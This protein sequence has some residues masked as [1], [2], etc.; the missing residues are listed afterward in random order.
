MAKLNNEGNGP[1][2]EGCIIQCHEGHSRRWTYRDFE[3]T[4]LCGCS[5]G[6]V[7]LKDCPARNELVDPTH[8]MHT[9]STAKTNHD[10]SSAIERPRRKAAFLDGLPEY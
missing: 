2:S 6:G 5:E 7:A 8:Q 9:G 10:S 1:G 3:S 4:H